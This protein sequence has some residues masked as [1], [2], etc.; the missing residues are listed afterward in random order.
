[1][2]PFI[3]PTIPPPE[4]WLDVLAAAYE[5]RRYSNFGPVGSRL[6]QELEQKY[7]SPDRSA[8]LVS[9]GTAGLIAVL[10]ALDVRGAVAM[11]SFTFP[12]TASAVALA[13]CRRLFVDVSSETWE[14]DLAQLERT[15]KPRSAQSSMCGLSDSAIPSMTSNRS[16][17]RRKCP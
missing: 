16:R 15:S 10:L 8:V 4:A 2:Y 1:M 5:E 17:E 13:G 3:R 14:L 11:P 6:E 9:S 12:A 7:L